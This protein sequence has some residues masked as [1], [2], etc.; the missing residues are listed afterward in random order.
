MAMNKRN[1]RHP[2]SWMHSGIHFA[3]AAIFFAWPLALFVAVTHLLIDTRIPTHWWMRRVKGMDPASPFFARL[4]IP[5]DQVLHY[6]TLIVGVY[7]FI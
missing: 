2:A 4:E 3:L 5:M 7:F 6:V 1:L